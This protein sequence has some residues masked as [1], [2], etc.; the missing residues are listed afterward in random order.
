MRALVAA[1]LASLLVVAPAAAEPWGTDFNMGTFVAYGGS[2][3]EGRISLECGSLDSGQSWAGQMSV[4]VTPAAE[5]LPDGGLKTKALFFITGAGQPSITLPVKREGD[6]FVASADDIDIEL[7]G[8]LVALL[9]TANGVRVTTATTP[10]HDVA[11]LSLEGSS[12]ALSGFE[13][14][15][16]GG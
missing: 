15:S 7:A 14:C 6:N 11:D 3:A 13:D 5:S 12:A 4:T 1:L 2:D 16:G 10:M 9:A 8:A